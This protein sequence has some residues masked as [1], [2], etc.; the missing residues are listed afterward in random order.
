[1]KDPLESKEQIALVRNLRAN[2]YFIFHVPNGGKR[3]MTEAI[4]MKAEGVMA[5]IPDLCLV[6][7]EGKMIWIELKRRKGGT[8]SKVQK[9]IHARLEALGHI[10]IIG[11]G[12]K[13]AF[14][15]L[16]EH[17]D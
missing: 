10:V 4:R 12:A 3:S 15:K 9:E 11:Y 1:M 14:D 16:G 17:I 8:V 2:G 6:M 5:G 13:D 7:P